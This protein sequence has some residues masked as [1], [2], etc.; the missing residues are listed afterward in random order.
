MM[1][2]Y[3]IEKWACEFGSATFFV[4]FVARRRW[5]GGIRWIELGR[6]DTKSDAE[7]ICREHQ[8]PP[9]HPWYYSADAL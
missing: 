3:K 7:K 2:R 4:A 8:H 6:A 5:W 1:Y 9:E